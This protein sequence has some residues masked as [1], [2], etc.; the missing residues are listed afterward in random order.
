MPKTTSATPYS[1]QKNW[2]STYLTDPKLIKLLGPFDTDPCCPPK[3][4]WA[5]A[6]V[7]YSHEKKRPHEADQLP[8]GRLI[9]A[10]GLQH[11]W[12]GRVFMNPPYRGVMRWANHFVTHRY[13]I[14]L[15]NGRSTETRATQ[16]IMQHS[17]AIWFPDHRLT[18]YKAS[19]KPFTQKWFPSLIIGMSLEDWKKMQRAQKKFGGQIFTKENIG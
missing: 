15:L 13:G 10:D 4:P 6:K 14:A 9:Y 1:D 2:S 19:G 12:R 16:L 17:T 7:M 3:M 8:G 5:T 11:L 18:F